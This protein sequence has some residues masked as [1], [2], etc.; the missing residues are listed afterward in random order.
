MIIKNTTYVDTRDR[1]ELA[2]RY[3]LSL[4]VEDLP[5]TVKMKNNNKSPVP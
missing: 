4:I 2:V 3:D 1:L 5:A